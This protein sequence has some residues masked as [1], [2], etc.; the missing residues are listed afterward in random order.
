MLSPSGRVCRDTRGQPCVAGPAEAA[1]GTLVTHLQL[2]EKRRAEVGGRILS[3]G[4][5]DGYAASRH[6]K[7]DSGDVYTQEGP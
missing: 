4:L 6:L 1:P 7:T 2:S 3:Q 5:E